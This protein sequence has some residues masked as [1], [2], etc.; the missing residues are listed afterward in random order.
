MQLQAK[1][2]HQRVHTMVT[3]EILISGLAFISNRRTSACSR[4]KM[5]TGVKIN[6]TK[7]FESAASPP[8]AAQ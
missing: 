6:L 3:S 7:L 5:N 1:N 8:E 2:R 4:G